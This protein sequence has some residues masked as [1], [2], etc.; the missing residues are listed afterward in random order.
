MIPALQRAPRAVRITRGLSTASQQ[1]SSTNDGGRGARNY[2]IAGG[3]LAF[4]GG[5]YY[6]AINK[7]MAKDDLD[8]LEKDA[9]TK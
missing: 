1:T 2:M 6:T 5:I 9:T 3:L 7:M 8:E 4:T